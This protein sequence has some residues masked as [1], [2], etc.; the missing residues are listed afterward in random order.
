MDSKEL[1]IDWLYGLKKKMLFSILGVLTVTIVVTMIFIAIKLRDTLINESK[2]KTRELAVTIDS[3]LRHLMLLRAPEAIQD[4]LEKIVEGNDSVSQV[5]ILNSQ[6]SVT[7][8][9]DTSIIGSTFDRYEDNSCSV[10]H[11]RSGTEPAS[12]AVVLATDRKTHRNISLI[13]NE[14]DC[15]ACHD[16]AMATN[17]KLIIDRSLDSTFSLIQ[18]IELI[19]IGSGVLCLIVLVPLFSRLLSRGINKYIVEIYTRNEEL[20]LLYVMVERLS[21][22]LDMVL[23][24]ESVIEIIKDILNADEVTLLLARGEKNFTWS[25]WT[26][27]SGKVERKKIADDEVLKQTMQEWL[28][29]DLVKTRVSA[30]TRQL[31]MPIEKGGQRLALVI[32]GRKGSHF[33]TERLKLCSV[34]SSHIA[35]A[36]DNARLYYIAIT[37]ELTKTFTKRHFRQCIEQTFIEYQQYGHKFAL[38]MMD[39]DKFK[40]VNDTYGH[41]AGDA[42]L[43]QLGEIIRSSVRE[44]DLIFRYG[45][46]EF[47]VILP[48]TGEKG[49]R[50]V[51]ERIRSTTE[52]AIFEPGTIDLKLTI[53]IG[54]ETCPEAPSIH[55]LIV[56]AD[57]A[58]YTAKK[59]GRNRVVRAEVAHGSKSEKES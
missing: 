16:P 19:L 8:S 26:R 6:G 35:V 30:D 39:L 5:I 56:A 34:I 44:N 40:Q 25:G 54:I 21:K 23:L 59:Q 27:K 33:D 2:I 24:K 3:N 1:K 51:A 4:T 36:F 12:D 22:T 28:A 48:N 32:A 20:R 11:T 7:Y 52:E 46:E 41:V 15:H 14:E 47:A 29:G 49:A 38:L 43:R 58:L 53:S 50:Y 42:V 45:G 55:D 9:S 18:E 31:F 37:D 57:Q 17:G 13:Y 10:C